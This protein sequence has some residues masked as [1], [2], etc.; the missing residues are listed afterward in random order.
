MLTRT[1]IF[2]CHNWKTLA[3]LIVAACC[4]FPS[5]TFAQIRRDFSAYPIMEPATANE[6]RTVLPASQSH[7]EVT[8]K[9]LNPGDYFL[10]R[11]IAVNNRDKP[12]QKIFGKGYSYV[13]YTNTAQFA[14]ISTSQ[15]RVADFVLNKDESPARPG[16]VPV[17]G[18]TIKTTASNQLFVK[19]SLRSVQLDA[20][21]KSTF[22]GVVGI[23]NRSIKETR[24]FSD[25]VTSVVNK[26]APTGVAD[27]EVDLTLNGLQDGNTWLLFPQDK[28]EDKNI[29]KELTAQNGKYKLLDN[30]IIN[31]QD[32]NKPINAPV[33]LLCS[34]NE[35]RL[36]QMPCWRKF[37][38]LGSLRVLRLVKMFKR[39]WPR[40]TKKYQY[41]R[42]KNICLL[43][44]E[45]SSWLERTI[46]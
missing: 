40:Q 19:L 2:S 8:A 37:K 28:N 30:V 3:L 21:K 9:K 43:S 46:W 14:Q 11:I 22:E 35:V 39:R 15:P 34:Y 32:K 44:S 33:F 20:A 41:H 29:T 1:H 10:L 42:R 23:V 16:T 25:F 24:L 45:T 18:P 31:T 5:N 38:A 6:P 27:V 7:P 4:Y 36:T 26:F 13:L 12:L 17:F